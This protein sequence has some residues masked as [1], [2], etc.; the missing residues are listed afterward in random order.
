[1]LM[2]LKIILLNLIRAKLVL[3]SSKSTSKVDWPVVKMS[4]GQIKMLDQSDKTP[5]SVGLL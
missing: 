2:V 1:M 3:K 4:R 5:D